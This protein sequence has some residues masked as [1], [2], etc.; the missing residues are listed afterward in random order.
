MREQGELFQQKGSEEP[1]ENQE[2]RQEWAEG[3]KG[4]DWK[5]R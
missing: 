2:R 4:F 5:T 1:V 3:I